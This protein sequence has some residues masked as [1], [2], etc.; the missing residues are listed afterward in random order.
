[1][2]ARQQSIPVPIFDAF[3]IALAQECALEL[4]RGFDFESNSL[5]EKSDEELLHSFSGSFNAILQNPNTTTR[6]TEYEVRQLARVAKIKAFYR[7]AISTDFLAGISSVE[8]GVTQ[9]V[10]KWRGRTVGATRKSHAL[11]A[12]INVARNF[13]TN[14]GPSLNGNY[15]VPLASRLLFYAVPEMPIF[16]FSNPLAK[17]LKL[18][19][20]PQA[21][22]PF[23]FDLMYK[24][25][26]TNRR[27]LSMLNVPTSS[28]LSV[29][30][31]NSLERSRWWT[32][33][34]LDL[35]LLNHFNL[36]SPKISL[37]QA[38][39]ANAPNYR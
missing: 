9:D 16:S 8:I 10:H 35:A 22:Y 4:W 3:E 23:F 32:R 17:K 7:S 13:V 15:R 6:I 25:I 5:K 19:T 2:A 31:Q 27:R 33:R 38:A 1:M 29:A 18:Q 39:R 24:G 14:S 11:N 12:V 30:Q 34:V 37:I 28:L 36:A 21:A 20:R 26:W